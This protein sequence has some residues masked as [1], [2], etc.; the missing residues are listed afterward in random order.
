MQN[1]IWMKLH[2]VVLVEDNLFQNK[3]SMFEALSENLLLFNSEFEKVNYYR[4]R[5]L[6]KILVTF[7]DQVNLLKIT[8]D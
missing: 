1:Y 6:S 4:H 5:Q 2:S 7:Y 8:F 3:T